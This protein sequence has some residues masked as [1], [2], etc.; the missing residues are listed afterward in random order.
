MLVSPVLASAADKCENDKQ[1]RKGSP[2]NGYGRIKCI[3]TVRFR[4]AIIGFRHTRIHIHTIIRYPWAGAAQAKRVDNKAQYVAC[5]KMI[6]SYCILR[7]EWKPSS[8]LL[9]ALGPLSTLHAAAHTLANEPFRHLSN[10]GCILP[11]SSNNEWDASERHWRDAILHQ[12]SHWHWISCMAV[13][14]GRRHARI[15]H[16]K[17][18]W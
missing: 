14:T 2:V 13:A 7:S 16:V 17:C 18:K 15:S 9:Y 11:I 6:L 1:P 8:N 4:V 5:Q 10:P 3:I 12:Q